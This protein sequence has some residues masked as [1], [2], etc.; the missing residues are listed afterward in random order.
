MAAGLRY[1]GIHATELPLADGGEGTL[2]VL[3]SARNGRRITTRVSGP[4]GDPVDADWG[5]LDDGTA[6]IEMAR[7]SGLPL[8]ETNDPAAA[9]STRGTG[10]LIQAAIATRSN[11]RRSS[12]SA[13]RRTTDGG[14]GAVEALDWRLP[15]PVVCACDVET[16]FVDAA[17]IFGP[18]KG[19]TPQQIVALETRLRA[20]QK[21]YGLDH[22]LPAREPQA[23]SREASPRS[24]PRC[25]PASTSSPRRSI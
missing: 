2:D 6:V 8:V 1:V 25:A 23:G 11:G 12:R 4:L 20:L 19:A 10:E 15:F 3:L 16:R 18:Q 17:K 21:R 22:D 5:L 7:A 13:V 24:A 14:L 9:P